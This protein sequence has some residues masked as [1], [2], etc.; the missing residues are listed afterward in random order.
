MPLHQGPLSPDGYKPEELAE[1]RLVR[2][3][4]QEEI[5]V[6]VQTQEIRR[7][8]AQTRDPNDPAR[9]VGATRQPPDGFHNDPSIVVS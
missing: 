7:R 4:S 6:A 3:P 5:R 9:L 2:P 8:M 1:A